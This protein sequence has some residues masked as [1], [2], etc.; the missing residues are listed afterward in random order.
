MAAPISGKQ[1]PGFYRQKV[2]D[3]EV[4]VVSDGT[5]TLDATIFT[6]DEAGA[7]KLLQRRPSAQ[8]GRSPRRSTPG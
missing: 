2:G 4:T 1:A 5:L 6:G 7:E 3:Y 8:D